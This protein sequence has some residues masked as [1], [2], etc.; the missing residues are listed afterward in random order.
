LAVDLSQ[1]GNQ[2]RRPRIGNPDDIL[3]Q[4]LVGWWYDTQKQ[5]HSKAPSPRPSLPE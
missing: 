1:N 3:Q 4:Q 2:L 5:V